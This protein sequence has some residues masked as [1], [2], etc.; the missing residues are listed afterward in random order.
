MAHTDAP[1][2][3]AWTQK[4]MVKK[5]KLISCV[6][7]FTFMLTFI[8]ISIAQRNITDSY[9]MEYV[10]STQIKGL[11][12]VNGN[13]Y[14]DVSDL[15]VRLPLAQGPNGQLPESLTRGIYRASQAL[16][17]VYGSCPSL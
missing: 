14:S 3:L 5:E 8:G 9:K 17:G 13:L 7:Y 6:F 10:L 12:D 4:R 2:N 1:N 16:L 15:Y 11:K